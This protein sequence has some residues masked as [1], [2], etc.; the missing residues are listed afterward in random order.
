VKKIFVVA[1]HEFT[2]TVKRIGFLIVTFGIPLFMLLVF[3]SIFFLQN[4]TIQQ[5]S[6]SID[7]SRVGFVDRSG[8]TSATPPPPG[9]EWKRYPDEDGARRSMATDRIEVLVVVH[10]DY[11]DSGRL[12][13]FTTHPALAALVRA[14]LHP[15]VLQGLARPAAS[16]WACRR[17]ASRGR[18]RWNI[19]S[20]N[21][22]RPMRR[23]RWRPKRRTTTGS[24]SSRRASS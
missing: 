12:D 16:W 24:G 5:E 9:S 20:S 23:A 14:Q 15:R 1:R 10:E 8:I 17:I 19:T 11:I 13:I 21:S 22:F 2:T 7:R 6:D 18:A 4:R 3:G